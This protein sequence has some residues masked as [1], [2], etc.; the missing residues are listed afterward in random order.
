MSFPTGENLVGSAHKTKSV[1]GKTRTS[2][3]N[4]LLKTGLINQRIYDETLPKIK[5]NSL[6]LE[7]YVMDFIT[8][9]FV[10]YEDFDE[11]LKN[12][13]AFLENLKTNNILSETQH[14]NLIK[15]YK[16]YELKRHFD[17]ISYCNNALVFELS[18]YPR[19]PEDYYRLIFNDIKKILPDFD[20]TNLSIK[21]FENP[22]FK[23]DL[24]ELKAS[25]SFD[26]KGRTYK[27]TFWHDFM[28]KNPTEKDKKEK[29]PPISIDFHKGIN[30]WLA[31]INSEKRLYYANKSDIDKQGNLEGAYSKET[32][33]LILLHE[34]QYKTWKTSESSYFLFSQSH[35]HTFNTER[36]KTIIQEYEKIGLFNHLS[37]A[38][39]DSA[40][41][42]VTES[43]IS[44]YQ[45]I[46][47]CF[48]KNI[49]YFDWESGNLENPYE[50][51]TLNFAAA[52]RG[53]FTPHTI[54]DN[55][56][57]DEKK[58]KTRYGFTLQGK[59]Y[60]TTL[61]MNN[62]WLDPQFVE[63]IKQAIK[64]QN[65]DG[66]I[67]YCLDNGQAVGYIF[68]NKRQYEYLK[69]Y[70]PSFLDSKD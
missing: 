5:S 70:H 1:S 52:S 33:G 12:Q 10:Y 55:F 20:F 32:F 49:I 13:L 41:M 68:L 37:K 69:K 44:N 64:D 24:I 4:A 39:I 6:F 30:K 66:N 16:P 19:N 25:I 2:L 46:L 15:S 67:Y 43:E 53:E 26:V 23:S 31:D 65:I 11:N 40:K 47:L 57:K 36:V 18:Q 9:R 38:E 7:V 14:K 8:E 34:K 17:F 63:L 48:P 62:D 35:D 54:K 22:R 3:L 42:K 56:L 50:E 59:K 61:K 27:N 60:E 45:D 28:K 21:V 58:E 51:L 29:L